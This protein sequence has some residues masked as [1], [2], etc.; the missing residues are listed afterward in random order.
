MSVDANT[1]SREELRKVRGIGESLAQ[2]IVAERARGP[3]RNLDDL[4]ARVRGIGGASLR[5]LAK[6]GL[7]VERPQAGRPPGGAT[8]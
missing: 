1:A 3:Y 6:A 2:R 8:R 4:A 7:R 5:N